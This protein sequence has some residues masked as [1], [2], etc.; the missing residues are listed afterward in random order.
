MTLLDILLEVSPEFSK[1][2][3][4][5]LGGGSG[6]LLHPSFHHIL[7]VYSIVDFKADFKAQHLDLLQVF[8]FLIPPFIYLGFNIALNTL[9]RSYHDG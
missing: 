5:T 4:Y 9:Y 6:S 8:V 1:R 3:F 7:Y 2:L